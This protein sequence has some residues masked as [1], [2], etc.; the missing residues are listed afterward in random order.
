MKRL[1]LIGLPIS[2]FVFSCEDV[3]SGVNGVDGVDGFSSLIRVTEEPSG[4]NCPNGG[5]KVSFGYDNVLTNGVLEDNEIT[6]TTYICNGQDGNNGQ[7]GDDGQD[8]QDGSA[9]VNVQIVEWS[10]DMTSFYEDDEPN[11]G[12]GGVYA[13]W[14]N[15]SLTQDVIDNGYVRIDMATSIEGPW[16]SLPYQIIDG[17]GTDVNWIYT[18]SYSYGVGAVR[19]DWDTTFGRTLSEWL[20]VD[21]LYEVYY[22]ITTIEE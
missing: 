11:D 6:S 9:N 20:D 4:F 21:F 5:S 12:D 1:L 18:T 14:S 13:V 10:S 16:F 7:D 8:G 2:L 22:K 3:A 19:V 15:S 17:D